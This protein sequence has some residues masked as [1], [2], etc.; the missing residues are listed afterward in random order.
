MI[1]DMEQCSYEERLNELGLFSL[2]NRQW[3]ID[4]VELHR[5]MKGMKKM[6]R[7][8]LFTLFQSP[9]K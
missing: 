4:V 6:I 9:R 5:I 8:Q 7:E 3:G 2:R 1:K